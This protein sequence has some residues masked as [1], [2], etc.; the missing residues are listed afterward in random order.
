MG[1]VKG[2]YSR[3][4]EG[5]G[6]IHLRH[7]LSKLLESIAA[8]VRRRVTGTDVNGAG[9]MT[10]PSMLRVAAG[11]PAPPTPPCRGASLCNS[12]SLLK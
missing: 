9:N 8:D 1:P 6:K 12:S 11:G 3:E 7:F 2:V 5:G 4:T 10:G